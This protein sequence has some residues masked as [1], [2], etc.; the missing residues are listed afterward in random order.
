MDFGFN[1]V[2]GLFGYKLSDKP[3]KEIAGKIYKF[4]AT[5][6]GISVYRNGELVADEIE[7]IN[8]NEDAHFCIGFKKGRKIC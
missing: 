5:P 8:Y 3:S 6:N 2:K 4:T 1:S 7:Q